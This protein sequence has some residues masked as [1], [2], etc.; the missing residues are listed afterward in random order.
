MRESAED[1]LREFRRVNVA[2]TIALARQAAAAGVR[3]FVFL[4]SIKVNGEETL[5]GDMFSERDAPAPKDP[6][7]VSKL[8]AEQGLLA[9]ARDT[10]MEMSIIRPVLVYGPGV[11][12]NFRTLMK[13]LARGV[14]LPFGCIENRRSLV[15][16]DNLVS[17]IQ[18][19][20]THADAPGRVFM[21][22]DGEDLSTTE[23]LHRTAAA[24][25]RRAR[26]VRVPPS[27]L[28]AAA[29]TAGKADMA[30]RLI[31][32]LQVDIRN[33]REVLGWAPPVCI[34]DALRATADHFLRHGNSGR[35]TSA[36]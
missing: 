1:P 24:L 31:G 7:G 6:Y 27:I 26:L 11:K 5:P 25:G 33:T 30:G 36:P 21:V 29:R 28:M 16:L 18:A 34:D 23:L 32:S 22:S 15:A 20:L 13:W 2:G 9:V 19:C 8:E 3:R 4:S 35:R 17:L 12:G 10:G 14:P